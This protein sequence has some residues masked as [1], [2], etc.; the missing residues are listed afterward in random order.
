MSGAVPLISIPVSHVMVSPLPLPSM[1]CIITRDTL[2]SCM[3]LKLTINLSIMT[4]INLS[5]IYIY[6]FNLTQFLALIVG[7]CHS[8]WIF[9]GNYVNHLMWHEGTPHFAHGVH[10]WALHVSLNYINCF[11]FIMDT[12][13]TVRHKI[14]VYILFT[15][16]LVCQWFSSVHLTTIFTTNA[17]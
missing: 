2:Y 8:P 7:S 14:S 12:V 6:G 4:A 5:Y 17:H 15:L 1:H 9:S 16:I 11:I 3:I 10:L 13:F